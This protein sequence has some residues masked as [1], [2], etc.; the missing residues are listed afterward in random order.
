MACHTS[1]WQAICSPLDIKD[2]TVISEF[3]NFDI[4]VSI[5]DIRVS[6][7][8]MT[9]NLLKLLFQADTGVSSRWFGLFTDNAVK[10][11]KT[12]DIHNSPYQGDM[13][14]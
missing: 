2:L 13:L 9:V 1:V 4:R 8:D 12:E 5:I 7:L 11:I 6:A 3:I 10:M 14:S